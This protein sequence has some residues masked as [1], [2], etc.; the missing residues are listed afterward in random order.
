MNSTSNKTR[1]YTENMYQLSIHLK[2]LLYEIE[3]DY[4][5]YQWVAKN[6]ENMSRGPP[7]I[8]MPRGNL[9]QYLSKGFIKIYSFKPR[10]N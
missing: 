9:L 5:W 4:K 7:Y 6:N 10:S 3:M 8:S 1:I 2:G